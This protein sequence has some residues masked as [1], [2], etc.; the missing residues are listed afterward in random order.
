MKTLVPLTALLLLAAAACSTPSATRTGM[1]YDVKIENG[2]A[3]AALA[4]QTGDEVRWVNHRTAPVNLY[5][6]GRE[7][8]YVCERGVTKKNDALRIEPGK[9]TSLCFGRPG[10]V[11]YHVRMDAS[12]P[13]GEVIEAGNIQVSNAREAR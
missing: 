6:F 11:G 8:D 13:G 10:N 12:V 9:A 7:N 1:I 5:F 3:P 4:V 2:I